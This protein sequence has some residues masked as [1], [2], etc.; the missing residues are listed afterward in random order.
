MVH[1]DGDGELEPTECNVSKPKGVLFVSKPPDLRIKPRNEPFD[2][3]SEKHRPGK[4]CKDI[5]KKRSADLTPEA[6]SFWGCLGKLH[7]DHG[8]VAEKV[9]NLPHTM[10]KDGHSFTFDGL[11]RPFFDV[12]KK[13]SLRF[14]R[15]HLGPDP[16]YPRRPQSH[17]TS[18]PRRSLH[19]RRRQRMRGRS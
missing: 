16:F 14:P 5:L 18:S 8:E 3:K 10:Q 15:P 6:K 4:V 12:M 13:I 11:S 17:G 7:D 1:P 2:H 9:P 19:Q